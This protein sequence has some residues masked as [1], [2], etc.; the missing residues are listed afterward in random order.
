MKKNINSKFNIQSEKGFT[1]Q[2]LIIAIFLLSLFVTLISG[3][4]YKVYI[5]NAKIS[6]TA[7]MAT[8]AVQILEDIDMIGY[9]EVNSE[10]EQ[11]YY[12]KFNIPKDYVLDIEVTNYGEGVENIEDVMKIVKLT[13]S[14]KLQDDTEQ[15]SV[16]KLKIKEM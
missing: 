12:N 6:L 4:M 14:Y 3:L 16:Q 7:Q 13:I 2:D 5:T 15:F 8:Y 9:N 1:M 11:N 10:L